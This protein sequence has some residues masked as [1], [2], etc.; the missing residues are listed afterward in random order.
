VLRDLNWD[1]LADLYPQYFHGEKLLFLI[2]L[3]GKSGSSSLLATTEMRSISILPSAS[4]IT[5]KRGHLRKKE[6]LLAR[7]EREQQD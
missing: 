2:G 1:D 3:P 5:G 6:T 7:R 4:I